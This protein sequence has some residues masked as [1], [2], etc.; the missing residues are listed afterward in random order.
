MKRQII[1]PEQSLTFSDYFKLRASTEDILNYFG[2]SKSNEH[3]VLPRSDREIKVFETLSA[4]L[5]E[6]II[7]ISLENELTRREFL[8]APIISEVRHLTDS[9]LRSEYWLEY[10]HQL[11]GSLDYYLRREG[12]LVVIEAKQADL[13][14]GFTQLAVEMI[15]LDKSEEIEGNL[16]YGAVSTGREWQF[17]LLLRQERKIVQ[18][19]NLY[20]L[21]VNLEDILRSLIGILENK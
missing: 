8:L 19:V 2:Y 11:R 17:G 3:L 10:N 18:D 13:T 15:A 9:K 6:H 16:I 1:L 14:R 21:L 5:E 7:H 12:N 20:V 4:R